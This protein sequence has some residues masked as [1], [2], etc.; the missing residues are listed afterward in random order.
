MKSIFGI[1]PSDVSDGMVLRAEDGHDYKA[2]GGRWVLIAKAQQVAIQVDA[3]RF[4]TKQ[5]SPTK[6]PTDI[7]VLLDDSNLTYNNPDYIIIPSLSLTHPHNKPACTLLKKKRGRPLK[8]KRNTREPTAY[9]KFISSIMSDV[10]KENPLLSN[11]ECMKLCA[12][13]WKAQARPSS[14][15]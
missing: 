13:R 5:T 8:E 14:K 4:I 10:K 15:A 2:Q 7:N 11:K 6:I 9:N 3:T 12:A 1:K